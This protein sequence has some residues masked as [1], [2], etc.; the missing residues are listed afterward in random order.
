MQLS[1][2]LF[3]HQRPTEGSALH[4]VYEHPLY[5]AKKL[6]YVESRKFYLPA[7]FTHVVTYNLTSKGKNWFENYWKARGHAVKSRWNSETR[8]LTGDSQPEHWFHTKD[9]LIGLEAALK[10]YG[11]PLQHWYDYNQIHRIL[12]PKGYWPHR[13]ESDGYL[14]YP[15]LQLFAELDLGT[16]TE[17]DWQDKTIKL[18]EIL[19]AEGNP[20]FPV[21][22]TNDAR[23]ETLRGWIQEAGGRGSFWIAPL[24]A[25][26]Q[27]ATLLDYPFRV[28]TEKQPFTL[29]QKLI[30]DASK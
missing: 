20:L 18:I 6:G 9:M 23:V 10:G 2:L 25:A 27:P 19:H 17:A 3:S 12:K 5:H 28:A 16:M 15:G 14:E 21:F 4:A 8:Y 22:T 24:S 11:S 29:R 7:E 26:L 13:A 1:R 30:L